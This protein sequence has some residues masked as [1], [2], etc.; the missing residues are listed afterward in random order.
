M[1]NKYEDENPEP[2]NN[3]TGNGK[4]DASANSNES[5]GDWKTIEEDPTKIK[6]ESNPGELVTGIFEF[7]KST[8][9]LRHGKYDYKA[10]VQA[11]KE[12]VVFEGYNVWI[13]ICSIVVAS[14]GLNMDSVAVVIGAMLISP[15][16]GPIRGIGFGV[17]MNDL[18]LLKSSV[19]NFGVM[20]GISLVTSIIYFLIT[21]IDVENS[22][23]LG[24]TEPNFLDAMIAFFGGLAG[25][26]AASNGKN[27]TV[28]NGVA[29]ATALMPPLCTAGWGIAN[30]EWTYF[31][32]A[33]YLFLL[34]SL[35]IALSTLVLLRYLR[36]P[37][38]EYVSAKIEKKVKNYIILFMVLII[39]PSAYLFYRMAKRSNFEDNAKVFVEKVVKRSGDNMIVTYDPQF[40][41]EGSVLELSFVNFYVDSTTIGQWDRTKGDYGLDNVTIKILQ[42]EDI[43]A[44]ADRK[45]KEAL[46]LSGNQNELINMLREK[47]VLIKELE[48]KYQDYQ[49]KEDAK[50]DHLDLDHLLTGFKVEYPEI[51]NMAINRSYSLNAKNAID[52][53]YIITVNFKNNVNE[54][55]QKKLKSRIN[56]KFCFE[57]KASNGVVLDSVSVVNF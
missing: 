34:N 45:I 20:V 5:K 22:Q 51:N 7:I 57:L 47:E 18:P 46:G 32:G 27:D 6:I 37:K 26:I 29:I 42:G 55:E 56:R 12:S 24:R 48:T 39:T 1:E 9:S 44:V 54:D 38:R 30:G 10:V 31:L 2:E 15:L 49:K 50:K 23:L 8:L 43:N 25:I 40:S 36:F 53:T 11:A 16:M 17:G 13:L 52:T 19:K 3:Q 14:I 35:F 41:M 28:I 21:P 33:S 4:D